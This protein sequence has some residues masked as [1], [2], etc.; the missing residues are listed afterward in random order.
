[1]EKIRN[2]KRTVATLLA[3]AICTVG[4]T[5]IT[6]TSSGNV[7]IGINNP[8]FTGFYRKECSF[9]KNKWRSGNK[10]RSIG[11]NRIFSKCN[12]GCGIFCGIRSRV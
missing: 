1:M 2:T 3:L 8:F 9:N 6:V 11:D 7:G 10:V 4:Y 12:N 5:Q